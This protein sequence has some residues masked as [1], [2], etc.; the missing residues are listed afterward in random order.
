M[1]HV[2][3]ICN[4]E[5]GLGHEIYVNRDKGIRVDPVLLWP[6]V[7]ALS[8]FS[9]E[10]VIEGKLRSIHLAQY[11]LVI[12]N[13]QEEETDP[14]AYIVLQDAFDNIGYTKAKIETINKIMK[15]FTRTLLDINFSKLIIPKKELKKINKIIQF[16][17]HFPDEISDSILKE[18]TRFQKNTIGIKFIS[19]YI[20]D[21]DEGIVNQFGQNDQ[22]ERAVF[23]SFIPIIP[24]NK[25]LWFEATRENLSEDDEL[26]KEGWIVKRIGKDTDFYLMGRFYYNTEIKPFLDTL[27]IRISSQLYDAIKK[28]IP[29]RPF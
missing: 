5:T 2:F 27:L 11:Q 9:K 18:I 29:K 8:A 1:I 7:G 20:A 17:Q 10:F 19:L 24:M 28:E 22:N 3:A 26:D 16:S 23:Q 6:L 13:P 15:V 4:I 14:M 12:Y 21:V 25:D